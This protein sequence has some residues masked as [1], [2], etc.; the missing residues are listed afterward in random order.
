MSRFAFLIKVVFDSGSR[1]REPMSVVITVC[2]LP[3]QRLMSF[4]IC[5]YVGMGLCF[6]PMDNRWMV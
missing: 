4:F 3:K 6:G 2:M 1:G 5:S